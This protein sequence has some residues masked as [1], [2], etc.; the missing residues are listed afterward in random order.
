MII[1]GENNEVAFLRVIILV[2][3]KH[4]TRE[5]GVMVN[6]LVLFCSPYVL[7]KVSQY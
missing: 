1:W 3:L 2:E 6:G 4:L 5:L 7:Y